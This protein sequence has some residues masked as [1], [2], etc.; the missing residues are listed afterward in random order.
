MAAGV[1]SASGGVVYSPPEAADTVEVGAGERVEW[2]ANESAQLWAGLPPE[3]ATLEELLLSREADGRPPAGEDEEM[4]LDVL[5]RGGDA[6]ARG[7]A[8]RAA[9]PPLLQLK[10]WRGGRPAGGGAD[11]ARS[12]AWKDSHICCLQEGRHAAGGLQARA[13]Q[14][15][16]LTSRPPAT[17]AARPP[18]DRS[19]APSPHPGL[20]VTISRLASTWH[21]A[22]MDTTPP[23]EAMM[24]APPPPLPL[25]L[26]VTCDL[27]QAF[28]P[29]PLAAP[30]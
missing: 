15:A 22:V 6:D 18:S 7:S 30:I 25:Q 11:A 20:Q 24:V 21:V 4:L 19:C 26:A 27:L 3:A 13:T 9:A 28:L 1:R 12:D 5:T 14:S 17:S 2:A 8:Q 23:P 10:A 16:H 29:P